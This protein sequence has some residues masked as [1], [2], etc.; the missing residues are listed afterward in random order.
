[1]ESTEKEDIKILESV[2]RRATKIVRKITHLSYEE[3]LD[4]LN[5]TSLSTR[6]LRG[7]LIQQCKFH[8]KLNQITWHHPNSRYSQD[9]NIRGNEFKLNKQLVK[10]CNS[11][12]I[13]FTN[14]IANKWNKL[15]KEIVFTRTI[16]EFK[17]KLDKSK[18]LKT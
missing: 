8:H 1:M 17:N 3:R 11:R 6:R 7:D 15:P 16:N 13:F 9:Y 2:Q 18:F 12:E 14:R 5:L 4:K 10:G